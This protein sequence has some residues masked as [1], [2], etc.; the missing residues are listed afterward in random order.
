MKHLLKSTER[1]RIRNQIP[2]DLVIYDDKEMKIEEIT[3]YQYV[4]EDALYS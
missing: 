3:I 2:W 1:E 4:E